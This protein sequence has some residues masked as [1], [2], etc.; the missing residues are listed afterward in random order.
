LFF[1]VDLMEKRAPGTTLADVKPYVQQ[2]L[3]ADRLDRLSIPKVKQ[4]QMNANWTAIA[5]A[6]DKKHPPDPYSSSELLLPA[7]NL[8]ADFPLSPLPTLSEADDVSGPA[9]FLAA[10]PATSARRSPRSHSV[11]ADPGNVDPWTWPYD[12]SLLEN[13]PASPKRKT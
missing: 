8:P 13:Q 2:L 5:A 3:G 9:P 6:Y 10:S 4:T 12:E 1:V 11:P 7:L